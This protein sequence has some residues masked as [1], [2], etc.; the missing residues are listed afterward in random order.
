MVVRMDFLKAV[1]SII[2][3]TVNKDGS[4]KKGG[5]DVA[6]E[7]KYDKLM[8]FAGEKA[9]E[10]GDSILQGEIAPSPYKKRKSG[11]WTYC[12]Y[13]SVLAVRAFWRTGWLSGN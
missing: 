3:V 8:T 4:Y 7:G 1:S 11:A 9:R 6:D 5:A 13:Q 2:P 12:N 10:I